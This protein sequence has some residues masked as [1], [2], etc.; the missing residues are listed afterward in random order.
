[1]GRFFWALRTAV[2]LLRVLSNEKGDI[3]YKNQ[4][5]SKVERLWALSTVKENLKKLMVMSFTFFS[6]DDRG[7]S[8]VAKVF[9][10]LMQLM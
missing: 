1:M 2:G 6:F 9:L 3:L 5:K 10:T 7:M 8:S 4:T